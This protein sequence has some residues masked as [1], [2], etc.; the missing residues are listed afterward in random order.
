MDRR[1]NAL[2]TD[3]PT[4]R[5]TDR[6]SYRGALSHLKIDYEVRLTGYELT[7]LVEPK[8]NVKDGDVLGLQLGDDS[9]QSFVLRPLLSISLVTNNGF[10][11][12]IESSTSLQQDAVLKLLD[13][14]AIS[15][16]GLQF[17]VVMLHHLVGLFG[18]PF[19]HRQIR[20][21]SADFGD[22][23]SEG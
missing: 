6:A 9:F 8:Q 20:D 21:E 13:G 14:D 10:D 5:P 3:R 16:F 7:F 1:T 15:R 11:F 18:K 12:R 17:D 4:D 19:F 23:G 2:Q 22:L